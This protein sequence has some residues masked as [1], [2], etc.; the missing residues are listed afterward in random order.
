M[1]CPR[2]SIETKYLHPTNHKG[3]RI[4]ARCD[5]GRKVIPWEYEL[6]AA[7]NHALAACALA[8]VL[9]WDVP[10]HLASTQKG[11]VAIYSDSLSYINLP[12]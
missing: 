2:Q 6:N 9:G 4:V 11:Y 3:A 8:T 5:A 12:D 1:I 7:E 10:T